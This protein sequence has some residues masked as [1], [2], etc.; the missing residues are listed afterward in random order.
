MSSI[1]PSVSDPDSTRPAP[2]FDAGRLWTGG[3]ATAA[4]AAPALL[5]LRWWSLVAGRL[6]ESLLR[7]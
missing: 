1:P 7:A 3:L 2:E 4:V 5:L 6:P